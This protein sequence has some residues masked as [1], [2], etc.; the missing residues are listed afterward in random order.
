MPREPPVTSATAPSR[1]RDWLATLQPDGLADRGKRGSAD[2]AE[3]ETFRDALR[4]AGRAGLRVRA[5]EGLARRAVTGACA[6]AETVRLAL[7]RER[8]HALVRLERVEVERE[9]V[10]RV[11]DRGVP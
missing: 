10:T 8:G 6:Y 7:L 3:E 1:S 9:P 4:A 2:A 5:P 11:A